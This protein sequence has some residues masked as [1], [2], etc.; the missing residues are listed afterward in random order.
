MISF[1]CFLLMYHPPNPNKN[2]NGKTTDGIIIDIRCGAL[3]LLVLALPTGTREQ[4]PESAS[5]YIIVVSFTPIGNPQV[6]LDI[7][8]S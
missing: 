6:V 1:C 2:T 3:E 4:T 5:T 8:A 7:D